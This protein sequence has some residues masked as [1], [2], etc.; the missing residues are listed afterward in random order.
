VSESIL[1][2]AIQDDLDPRRPRL[3]AA[4]WRVGRLQPADPVPWTPETAPSTRGS[5]IPDRLDLAAARALRAEAALDRL[6]LGVAEADGCGRLRFANRAALSM[7]QAEDG[8]RL[9]DGV[10]VCEQAEAA[11]RLRAALA[12]AARGGASGLIQ[13]ARPSGRRSYA[14]TVSAGP[15][16]GALV[17]LNDGEIAAAEAPARLARLFGL[18]AAEAGLAAALCDG[19]SLKEIA[20]ARGVKMTTVRTQAQRVLDKAGVS[21]QAELVAVVVRAPAL[22]ATE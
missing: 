18:T 17:L 2:N 3:L 6:T 15:D 22:M 20:E 19:L 1:M 13:A 21:R 12:T 10:L 7:L 8:L 14:I 11:R 16:A 9:A 5:E 4:S